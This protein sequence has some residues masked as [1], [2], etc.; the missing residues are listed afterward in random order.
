M[1][2]HCRVSPTAP[3]RLSVNKTYKLFIGGKFPR[4]E[5]RRS[6]A[7]GCVG[8]PVH[9]AHASRK[10]L[11]EA[12]E[13][14]RIAQGK[15]GSASGLNRGQ[16]LYRLAEMTEGKRVELSESVAAHRAAGKVASKAKRS[17]DT[18]V[19]AA[20]DRLVAYAGW[21]DKY[22]QVLGCNNPVA[23]PFYNFTVPEPVGVVAVV[24]PDALPLL[25]LVA[26]M[27]PALCS[28]NTVVAFA[29]G[30]NPVPAAVFAEAVA[31][32]DVP[33]GVVNILTGRRDELLEQVASHG[34]IDAIHAGGLTVPENAVLR[35]GAGKNLKRVT[36]REG[37]GWARGQDADPWTIEPF[38]EMKTMWHPSA[39]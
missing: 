23:G 9:I 36:V 13:V 18:E 21:A 8:G 5:S 16:V 3:D 6:I 37:L 4:S 10:D 12:V 38:V 26:L 28:G 24:A 7:V 14:A 15:W 19:T 29:S 27:A 33:G 22:A 11:R 31:T 35:A 25:G 17:P 34:E 20:I 39:T 32:S 2:Y 1:G 30:T